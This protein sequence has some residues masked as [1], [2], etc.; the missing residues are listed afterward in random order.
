MQRRDA[1]VLGY[2]ALMLA[3]LPFLW[4]R[5]VPLHRPAWRRRPGCR[6][7]LVSRS[8]FRVGG[9]HSRHHRSEPGEEPEQQAAGVLVLA[10]VAWPRSCWSPPRPP[11]W[12][13]AARAARRARFRSGRVAAA[14]ATRPRAL[15]RL[16]HDAERSAYR[17]ELHD[18]ICTS[19]A[20]SPCRP[21]S[22]ADQPE[23]S[24]APCGRRRPRGHRTSG[25]DE[26]NRIVGALRRDSA[27]DGT[28]PQPAWTTPDLVN[29]AR[30]ADPGPPQIA[31]P[32]RSLAAP[33]TLPPTGRPGVADERPALCALGADERG[34][35]LPRWGADWRR[36]RRRQSRATGQG[37]PRREPMVNSGTRTAG[38]A[39]RA[40]L[41]AALEA[42][43][44]RG[45][46]LPRLATQ[47]S[48]DPGPARALSTRRRCGRG[49]ACPSRLARWKSSAG[50]GQDDRG[51][52]GDRFTSPDVVLMDA[53]CPAST[54]SRPLGVSWAQGPGCRPR[55]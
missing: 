29:G 50:R 45:I 44:R 51:Q 13:P 30:S 11:A 9:F 17:R 49:S 54:A 43:P 18:V 8:L 15:S 3:H 7:Q 28:A 40:Q 53:G 31:G 4:W 47:A 32:P 5:R 42:A 19:S 2:V 33:S 6:G 10:A 48:D 41:L 38:P 36:G 20:P 52:R 39:Q 14:I 24:S 46:L 55:S 25:P 26:L 22:P 37:R 27:I 35:E 21:A 12:R 1:V 16:A 34:A 23:Q